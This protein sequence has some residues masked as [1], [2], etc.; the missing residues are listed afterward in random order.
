MT[1]WILALGLA[2][3]SLAAMVLLFRLPRAAISAIAA[4]LMLGLAGYAFQGEP[5]KQGSPKAGVDVSREEGP[6]IV[7]ARQRLFD[8]AANPRSYMILADG[9]TR[10]GQYENAAKILAEATRSY[11]Q[12][13]EAWTALG[14]VLVAHAEGRLAAPARM[15]YAKASEG[16]PGSVAPGFFIG[17]SELRAGKLIEAHKAWTTA[18]KGAP[19]DAPGRAEV[20][21]RLIQ[22][23][24]LI[25]KIAGQ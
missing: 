4:A 7:D 23:E 2:L 5:D 14:N 18:L 17:I 16:D 15:A 12:D 20:A 19:Q 24:A 10:N 25:R 6:L 1:S 11:P 22:L 21:Q 8:N 3:A 13:A 9:F